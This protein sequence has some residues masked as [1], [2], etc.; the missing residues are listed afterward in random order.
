MRKY[1]I[2]TGLISGL[3]WWFMQPVMPETL[4]GGASMNVS[5]SNFKSDTDGTTIRVNLTRYETRMPALTSEITRNEQLN[6]ATQRARNS[7][8][9]AIGVATDNRTKRIVMVDPASSVYGQIEVG[10]YFLKI[11][12]VDLL[13]ATLSRIN[14]GA[15]N[16]YVLVLFRKASGELVT[17]SV[18]RQP[19]ENF[20][21]EFRRTLLPY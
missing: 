4:I 15:D 1:F 2:V 10:D 20:T 9:S 5:Q 18:L 6:L 12:N 7:K 13:P 17:L 8:L 3:N 21:P 16:T 19:V 11:N 14:Y